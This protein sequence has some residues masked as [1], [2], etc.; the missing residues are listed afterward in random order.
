MKK[1]FFILTLLLTFFI[2]TPNRVKAQESGSQIYYKAAVSASLDNEGN[3]IISTNCT[4]LEGDN[5]NVP[6][7][8]HQVKINIKA[9][10]DMLH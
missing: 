10:I 1:V 2:M 3:L 8:V 6:G 5:C 7:S 9:I 4:S